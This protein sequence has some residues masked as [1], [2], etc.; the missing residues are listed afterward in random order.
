MHTQLKAVIGKCIAV[1][2]LFTIVIAA[3][4]QTSSTYAA[5]SDEPATV[6]YIGTQDDMFLFNVSYKN[7]GGSTFTMIVKDQDGTALYRSTF[8]EKDFNRQFRLP[9]TDDRGKYVFVF[10]NAS[11]R[12]LAKTFEI[13]VNRRYVDNNGVKRF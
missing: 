12:D 5:A 2:L 7:P 10:R 13:N 9:K 1:T 11:G 8:H 3:Q 4:A 6:Q